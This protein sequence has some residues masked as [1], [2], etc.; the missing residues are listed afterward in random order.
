MPPAPAVLF[1]DLLAGFDWASAEPTENAAYVSRKT[2]RVH[3]ASEEMELDEE[4]PP[5]ID[6]ASVYVAVP[7][8]GDLRL[9]RGLALAF[10]REHLAQRFGQVAAFF[11]HH[12]AYARFKDLLDR[13]GQ[14][15][16]WYAHEAAEIE[17]ALRAWAADEGLVLDPPAGPD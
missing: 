11:D 4:L 12:G 10:A 17:R 3:W 7:G 13:E 1:D 2:G 14:L 15:D 8:K 16:A 9:G 6:D 5:D